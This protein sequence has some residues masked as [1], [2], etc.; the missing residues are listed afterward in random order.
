MIIREVY[1]LGKINPIEYL[2]VRRSFYENL[3]AY[4]HGLV[5]LGLCVFSDIVFT[6][7]SGL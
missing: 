7:S 3:I 6:L 2:I 1:K 4:I 5:Y